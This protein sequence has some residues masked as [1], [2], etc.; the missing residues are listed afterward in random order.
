MMFRSP[1]HPDDGL[2][3]VIFTEPDWQKGSSRFKMLLANINGAS[4][5]GRRHA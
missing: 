3:C 1:D 5:A 4:A 2:G